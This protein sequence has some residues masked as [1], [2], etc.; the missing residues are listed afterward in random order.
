MAL[1]ICDEDVWD[2]EC[3]S[4]TFQNRLVAQVAIL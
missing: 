4:T 3:H 1:D 2:Y